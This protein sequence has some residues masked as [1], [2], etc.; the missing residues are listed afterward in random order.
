MGNECEVCGISKE[1]YGFDWVNYG[2]QEMCEQC[3]EEKIE[4]EE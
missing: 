4:G 3:Y 1:Y 2:G